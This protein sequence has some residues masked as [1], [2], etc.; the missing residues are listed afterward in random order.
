MAIFIDKDNP[1]LA[2]YPDWIL[3]YYKNSANQYWHNEY[4]ASDR[5][6]LF[7]F[8]TRYG[9]GVD[10]I[11][12][13]GAN[14][15]I[16]LRDFD[17]AFED[18]TFEVDASANTITIR[19]G[20][21]SRATLT[22]GTE[23]THENKIVL[24]DVAELIDG[25]G[26]HLLTASNFHFPLAG[27][28]NEGVVL[29]GDGRLKGTDGDDTLTAHWGDT[30]LIG[31][32]GYDILNGGWG[33]DYLK[34]GSGDDKLNGSWGDDI[35]KGNQGD[36]CLAGSWGDDTLHGGKGNDVLMSSWGDDIM[37]GGKGND[38]MDSGWGAETFVFREG[39]GHDIID[40][41]GFGWSGSDDYLPTYEA[42]QAAKAKALENGWVDKIQIHL[43]IAAHTM[44]DE[45]EA[46]F[47]S[48]KIR[49]D[50]KDTVIGYGSEGDT[51]T[52]KDVRV[53]EVT[54]DDFEFVFVG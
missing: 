2:N 54:I 17:G 35:L 16:R 44:D 43:N 15:K 33:D 32:K 45:D 40:D 53:G 29:S 23:I 47:E 26:N 13:F 27:S 38:F 46:A 6:D 5:K 11:S 12:D 4:Q 50:G 10:T 9:N 30:T 41:F 8:D 51:I 28:S 18:L 14:D 21:D 37:C 34:G 52:L 42:R 7:V 36:D 39:D 3:E 48:L 25:N 49:K 24:R 22:D 31:G 20:G 19:Y 1:D